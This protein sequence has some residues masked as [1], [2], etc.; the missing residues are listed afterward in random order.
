MSDSGAL[1]LRVAGSAVDVGAYEIDCEDTFN[2]LDWNHDGLV[3]Y[4]EFSKFSAAWLSHDPN[5]PLWI[6]DPN[7]ADPNLSEAWNPTCNLVDTG[8]S[9]YNIDLADLEAFVFNVPWLWRACWLTDTGILSEV[10]F[11]G[12]ETLLMS[13]DSTELNSLQTTS[14]LTV[15]SETSVQEQMMQ[16][17]DSLVFLARIWME[18]PDIQQQISP[19][20]WQEFMGAVYQ[21]LLELQ[22]NEI[23]IE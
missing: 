14:E 20:D 5:D 21:S 18:E 23:Q 16:L 6:A 19:E 2:D 7:L 9:A 12:G 4:Y 3:N 15:Q 13:G 11:G 8:D 22:T 1:R 10:T 17:Q